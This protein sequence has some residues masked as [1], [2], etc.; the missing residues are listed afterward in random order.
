MTR[1]WGVDVTQ[2]CDQHL[3][4]EHSEHHQ[5]VGTILRHQHGKAIIEG[6][7]FDD[8]PD[9]IDTSLIQHRHDQLARELERRDMNHDSE[10]DFD[11]PWNMGE[12]DVEYNKADL[13]DRCE[14]CF[15]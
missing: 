13:K 12:I 11:D 2:M 7:I 8:Q 10:M 6:R 3:L 4:G 1:Q 9:Q 14:E 5:A 15:E